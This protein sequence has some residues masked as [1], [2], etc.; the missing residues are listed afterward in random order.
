MLKAHRARYGRY[1]QRRVSSASKGRR[2]GS[3]RNSCA[4]CSPHRHRLRKCRGRHESAVTVAPVA[5]KVAQQVSPTEAEAEPL[6][7]PGEEHNESVKREAVPDVVRDGAKTVGDAGHSIA[8]RFLGAEKETLLFCLKVTRD[9]LKSSSMRG[10][11]LFRIDHRNHC[12]ALR[13]DILA[14]HFSRLWRLSRG[15]VLVSGDVQLNPE[16]D[17]TR[18]NLWMFVGSLGDRCA[19]DGL[20]RAKEI[21]FWLRLHSELFLR[22]ADEGMASFALDERGIDVTL[23]VRRP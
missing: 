17:R 11:R 12:A 13:T 7:H 2:V 4:H 23:D 10:L 16:L 14:F 9:R 5:D 22:L 20:I 21:G 18:E 15:D 8:E 19:W 1:A 6:E 3:P